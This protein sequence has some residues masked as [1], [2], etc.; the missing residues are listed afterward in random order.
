MQ[1]RITG[2]ETEWGLLICQGADP[3]APL[4]AE[5]L[6]AFYD[7]LPDDL[8]RV[9]N[10]L[11]NGSKLHVDVGSHLEYATP[12][13]D[14][15]M[16]TL[17]NELAGEEIVYQLLQRMILQSKGP[18]KL[19]AFQLN[20]RVLDD[21]GN[22]WGYHE[23]YGCNANAVQIGEE[24]LALVGLHL[25]TRNFFAG[26]GAATSYGYVMSQ[27]VQNLNI[28]Y[29]LGSSG[30]SQPLL[31]GRKQPLAEGDVWTR[32]HVTSGDANMSPWA[33]WMKLGT[34]SLVLRL[35]E[36]G[37]NGE[38]LR[39]QKPMFYVAK[40]A[41][42]DLTGSKTFERVNGE[43]IKPIEIQEALIEKVAEYASKHD[44]PQE[45][46]QVLD[47]WQ[48]AHDD[49]K[50]DPELLYDR[51]DWVVRKA[52]I[53]R[54]IDPDKL[55]YGSDVAREIDRKYDRIAP[56][57]IGVGLRRKHWAD[58]M[59]PEEAIVQARSHAPTTTRACLRERYIHAFSGEQFPHSTVD[60]DHG[61]PKD[62]YK[63]PMDDP[64]STNSRRLDK[65]IK[66]MAA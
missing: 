61:S 11:S 19:H 66:K 14:S 21:G 65:A 5:S 23:N 33:T 7:Y 4:A 16:G 42:R 30:K 8:A 29:D 48:R 63:I 62:G 51:V 46:K 44:I 25:A 37:Y 12:E 57:G 64:R 53:D 15:I 52:V 41:S 56:D 10:F 54:H 50:K 35:L 59:P 31:S 3:K 47:E 40:E 20:K 18:N 34:T 27:K 55:D 6:R 32:V 9:G 60:W 24:E 13:D 26:A 43:T 49:Y 58:W 38:D 17:A 36:N 45:E 1:G 22:T 2:T 39:L 28:E